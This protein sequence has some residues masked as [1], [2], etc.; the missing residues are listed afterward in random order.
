MIKIF[1]NN[2]KTL[3]I[4]N[5]IEAYIKFY[6]ERISNLRYDIKQYDGIL[7]PKFLLFELEVNKNVVRRLTKLKE[8]YGK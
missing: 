2:I 6:C 5:N 3:F 7:T 8:K 1:K 4:I